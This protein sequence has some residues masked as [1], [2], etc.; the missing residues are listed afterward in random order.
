MNS[1]TK[2]I[3]SISAL[4]AALSFAWVALTI[5]GVIP[6]HIAR[7]TMY[8]KGNVDLGGGFRL[9]PVE[10]KTGLAGFEIMHSGSIEV[11]R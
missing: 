5:T 6:D 9:S 1:I 11:T 3:F 8:H 4:I 7:V 2:L 10:L